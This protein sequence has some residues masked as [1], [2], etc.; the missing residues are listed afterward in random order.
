LIVAYQTET[1][2]ARATSAEAKAAEIS[3]A[4]GA[5]NND[6]TLAPGEFRFTTGR[7]REP[8]RIQGPVT[9]DIRDGIRRIKIGDPYSTGVEIGLSSHE[10]SL[11][12]VDLGNR[13]GVYF[14]LFN[15]GTDVADPGDPTAGSVHKTGDTYVVSGY[16]TGS[17]AAQNTARLYFEIS[18]ACP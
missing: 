1:T 6:S 14:A 5:A 13:G 10:S 2:S 15:D 3:K 7:D 11:R 9:C 16:A 4:A 18:V 17:T 8:Q 12:Y